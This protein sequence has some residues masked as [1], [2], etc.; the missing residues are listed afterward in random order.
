MVHE[1][2]KSPDQGTESNKRALMINCPRRIPQVDL[3][4]TF[5]PGAEQAAAVL[6]LGED[7]AGPGLR[8]D[9]AVDEGDLALE[10]LP[11]DR[12]VAALQ[13]GHDP[14]SLP[15]A[16]VPGIA[17][18]EVSGDPHPVDGDHLVNRHAERDR[19]A[20]VL[21]DLDDD[22]IVGADDLARGDHGLGCMQLGLR[23]APALD[24]R[25]EPELRSL[26]RVP[27]ELEILN[28]HRQ[29]GI[30]VVESL[31]AP[32]LR[33]LHLEGRLALVDGR[34]AALEGD[35]TGLQLRQ[36]ILVEESAEHL[37]ALHLVTRFGS[38]LATFSVSGCPPCWRISRW[39][40]AW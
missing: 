23:H 20:D 28:A 5:Q 18:V 4:L 33:P 21:V 31:G 10:D 38:V 27:L 8:V 15:L 19:L 9:L 16:D 29:E 12:Q 17:R 35:G 1:L 2:L 39:T 32:Q 14:D 3:H 22:A 13:L 36:D 34:L 26:H 24:R 40:S 37:P 6:H 7:P 11:L 25:L 30:P